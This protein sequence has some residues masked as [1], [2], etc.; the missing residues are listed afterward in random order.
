M[1]LYIDTPRTSFSVEISK[2]N[3]WIHGSILVGRED[4]CYFF[5]SLLV[6]TSKSTDE[7]DLAVLA[8]TRIT[9][10]PNSTA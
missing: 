1:Y 3:G 6:R 7:L 2:G 4:F 5:T 10:D 9:R 8:V